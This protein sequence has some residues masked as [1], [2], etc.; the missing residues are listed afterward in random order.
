MPQATSDRS[1]SKTNPEG[2]RAGDYCR[3]TKVA[4]F[5][6]Y[7]MIQVGHVCRVTHTRPSGNHQR[8]VCTVSIALEDG[9]EFHASVTATDL[10]ITHPEGEQTHTR[11]NAILADLSRMN[12]QMTHPQGAMVMASRLD[13]SGRVR[14]R[15]AL[16]AD[17][18]RMATELATM[19]QRC[20][21]LANRV[22]LVS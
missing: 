5:S 10:A 13:G 9:R 18:E 21:M 2:I 14:D 22:G 19:S 20:S 4:A 8:T 6:N 1:V 16:I 7:P 3:F 12:S 15:A 17:L 11:L